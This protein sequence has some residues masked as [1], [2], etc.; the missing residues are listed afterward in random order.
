MQSWYAAP[1]AKIPGTPVPP[2]IWDTATKE[3]RPVAAGATATMYVCGITP[4]DATHLGHAATYV[5]FDLLHR[6]LLDGGHRVVYVQNVTDIDDDV[7]KRAR[8]TGQD[9]AELGKRETTLFRAD[10]A[11]LAVLPPTH[12]VGAV[13]AMRSIV[14]LVA[15]LKDAGATYD[16][17]GDVYLS[18]AADERFGSVAGLDAETMRRLSAERGGDPDRPGKKHPLDPLLWYA[19]R[20]GEPGWE[21]PW[22][23][24]RPGWHVECAAIA[25]RTIGAPIDVQGG[26]SDLAFP[27]HEMCAAEATLATGRWPFARAFVHTG[28]VGLDGEKMSK[29]LGNLVFVRVLRTEH[30][31]AAIR[32]ALLA[33]HYRDDWMWTGDDMAAAERRYALWREAATAP[34]GGPAEPV[35]DAVR[36]T[37]A[38]DLDAP[39]ALAAVDRWAAETIRVGGPSDT[40][41]KQVKQAVGALLGVTL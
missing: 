25:L 39:R 24:G 40:A 29:S 33:H 10:M 4:Y 18:V 22:G 14:D 34:F 20:P 7:L 12:Y 23:P 2:R 9:W 17:E 15:L 16:V 13:E 30:A 26:G 32:L 3:L 37:L 1:P 27:H 36:R 8:E 28:M 11:A 21:S 5:A 6:T 31:P 19:Q 41:G 38:D 35:I